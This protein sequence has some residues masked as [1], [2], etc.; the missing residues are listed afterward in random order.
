MVIRT[1]DTSLDHPPER[2]RRWPRRLL[3]VAMILVVAGVGLAVTDAVMR[4]DTAERGPA[5]VEQEGLLSA[6]ITEPPALERDDD[7]TVEFVTVGVEIVNAGQVAVGMNSVEVELAN[8][9]TLYGEA[10]QESLDPVTLAPGASHDVATSL[11]VLGVTAEEWPSEV[12]EITPQWEP[13]G[14]AV[15]C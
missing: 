10:T 1:T 14:S 7:G 4:R 9:W 2:R 15:R 8:G 3:V 11:A 13:T 6:Q 12:V 5:C